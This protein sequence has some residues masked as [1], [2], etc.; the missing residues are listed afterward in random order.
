MKLRINSAE[1]G[2]LGSPHKSLFTKIGNKYVGTLTQ[3][4]MNTIL[5]KITAY[6]TRKPIH[7][8]FSAWKTRVRISPSIRSGATRRVNLKRGTRSRVLTDISQYTRMQPMLFEG[9]THMKHGKFMRKVVDPLADQLL[10]FRKPRNMTK[11]QLNHITRLLVQ[12]KRVNNKIPAFIKSKVSIPVN[13]FINASRRAKKQNTAAK[14]IQCRFRMSMTN[15]GYK[16][17]R[18][19]LRR[20][21][22]NMSF[23]K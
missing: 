3:N 2:V 12:Y 4:Q 21:F 17:C 13:A 5:P 23:N 10:Q 8:L 9:Y 18:N 6:R 16:M 15:P 20:E 14:L 19:R 11:T 7:G 22:E 1:Y